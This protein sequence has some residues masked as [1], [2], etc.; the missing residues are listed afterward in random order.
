MFRCWNDFCEDFLFKNARMNEHNKL[1]DTMTNKIR[2][3]YILYSLFQQV[4]ASKNVRS[5][6]SKREVTSSAKS[7]RSL[8]C[9][10]KRPRDVN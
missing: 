9:D 1:F 4:T 6:D 2:Y 8:A 3:I 7:A 5:D 10:E